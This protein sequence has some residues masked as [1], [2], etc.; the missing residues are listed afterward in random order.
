RPASSSSSA[1]ASS[2]TSRPSAATSSM[3]DDEP[4]SAVPGSTPSPGP[5]GKKP[6]RSLRTQLVV[7][8]LL[9]AFGFAFVVQ[10]RDYQ[11]DD[12]FSSLRETELVQILDGLTGTA[13]RARAEIERLETT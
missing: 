10:I 5:S 2:P 6:R 13:E 1:S 8:V 7:A 12:Q 3:P 9:A 11:K 4:Q